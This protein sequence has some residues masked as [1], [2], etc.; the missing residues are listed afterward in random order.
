IRQAKRY[1]A[2]YFQPKFTEIIEKLNK[3]KNGCKYLEDLVSLIGHPSNPPLGLNNVKEKTFIITETHLGDYFPIGAAHVGKTNLYNLPVRAICGSSLTLIRLLPQLINPYYLLAFLNSS[4]GKS[5]TRRNLRGSVQQC[6]Y[7]HDTKK[8]PIP[9]LDKSVQEQIATAIHE[10]EDSFNKSKNLLNVAKKAVEMAIEINEDIAV[11]REPKEA[12]KPPAKTE[13]KSR[14]I[15]EP[16]DYSTLRSL[17]KKQQGERIT[18]Y[19]FK[20][21]D[22][23]PVETYLDQQRIE[24]PEPAGNKK[25]H[26]IQEEHPGV[27]ISNDQQNQFSPVVTVI[28]LTSQITTIDKIYV[29]RKIASLTEKEMREIER[30]LHLTLALSCYQKESI[31]T[32][33]KYIQPKNVSITNNLAVIDRI[34]SK[35]RL[36]LFSVIRAK[37]PT[38]IHELSKLLNRDYANVWR[39]CQVLA[40][41]KIIELKGQGKEIQPLALYDQIVIEF[42]LVNISK[43]KGNEVGLVV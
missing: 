4:I 17:L 40:S 26:T 32:G 35:T 18:P 9:M 3:Y 36:E 30:K 38:N 37:Q 1:D 23:R 39:D 41:C 42:P 28:P 25:I 10:G 7:S 15:L 20:L 5:L 34:L 27:I 12:L 29:K 33:Q 6:I 24:K 8:V 31:K 2:E 43:E 14:K 22:S 11:H 13:Q 21:A 16:K 19:I